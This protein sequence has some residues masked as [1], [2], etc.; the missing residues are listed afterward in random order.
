MIALERYSLRLDPAGPAAG[1]AR[2]RGRAVTR[3]Q[4]H[5]HICAVLE[6]DWPQALQFLDTLYRQVGECLA[7]DGC[8]AIWWV[9]ERLLSDYAALV[10]NRSGAGKLPD[11]YRFA[12]VVDSQ[13]SATLHFCGVRLED[14]R[15]ACWTLG[16]ALRPEDTLELAGGVSIRRLASADRRALRRVLYG[17]LARR[18]QDLLRRAGYEDAIVGGVLYRRC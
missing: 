7:V 15:G 2:T 4:R 16:A 12:A 13:I 5:G 17:R 1:D 8:P 11:Y 10:A 6:H 14:Q 18:Y 9:V 3:L